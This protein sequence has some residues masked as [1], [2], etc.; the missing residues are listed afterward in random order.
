MTTKRLTFALM[1]IGLL[2]AQGQTAESD[3]LKTATRPLHEVVVTG[4]R[5]EADTRYLTQTV[6]IIDRRQIEQAHNPSLLPVL[7]EQV[8]GLFVTSRG[9]LVYG[10]S[11]GAAGGI[12]LR[13]LSGGSGQIMVLIDG[14]PQYMGLMGHPISDAYQSLMA[15]R[16]EVLRGPASALYGSNA[17][18][19]VINIITRK[20]QEDGVKTDIDLGYGSYNT[21]QS[22]ATNQVRKGRFTSIVSASYNRTDG[23]RPDLEFEQYGG[24]AKL[25]YELTKTWDVRADLDITHFNASQPGSLDAP[26]LD[27]DQRITRGM[28]SVAVENR[29]ERTSGA[30][31]LFYNWGR[32]KINDGYNPNAGESPLDYRFH[33]RDNMMG[34]SWYQSARLF[35]GN[36]LTVGVDWYRFGGEAWNKFIAGEREDIV[37]KTQNEVAGYVDFRQDIGSWLAFNAGVRADHHEQVGTE[38][39]PQAGLAFLLPRDAN[40]KLTASRGFRYP[41]LR[42]MYMFPPQ[43]PDLK[44]ES[45]WNYEI[46]FSQ[47]LLEGR[48]SYGANLFYID[49]KNLIMTLPNPHG[50]GRINQNSG[51]I[52]NSGVEAQAAYRISKSWAANANYSF[53]HMERP[54]ISAPEHKLHV[55]GSFT[56]GR[57]DLSTGIQYIKGL[58]TEVS[59]NDNGKQEDFVLWNIRGSFRATNFLDIYVRG[60]NLLAQRY[61]IMAGYPMPKAT[62]IGGVKVRF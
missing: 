3:S 45:M 12:S 34:L 51:K 6:S 25:G 50:S 16:V 11:G 49:G 21:L 46:A 18:G 30:L 5:N 56:Q 8:P 13:G 40:I 17:M 27:A 36:R 54:V 61:E 37:D 41:T 19:G 7:T 57:W 15:D 24:Y 42:E 48:L 55:G 4:T 38:W 22:E 52:D 26:L 60:E 35:Q 2:P 58:Y 33:S 9:I 44:P 39:I 31:S 62:F 47:E 14:H 53:L 10:V 20:M 28:A 32:H 43:N 29:Y 1:A 23:H 59:T